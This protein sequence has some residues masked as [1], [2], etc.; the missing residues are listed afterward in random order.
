MRAAA[1][2]AH[3][4][5]EMILNPAA[6]LPSFTGQYV[7]RERYLTQV[8]FGRLLA[9][10]SSERRLWVEVAVYSGGRLSEVEGLIWEEHVHLD[11]A[12]MLLPG[13][14]TK[15][16]RRRVPI[17][18]PLLEALV[19]SPRR[20]GSVVLPWK[21]VRRDLA[22]ACKTAAIKPVTPND[23]RRTFASWMTQAGVDSKAVADLLGHT[24]TRMVDRCYGHLDDATY[25]RALA[26]LPGR[27]P[28]S[29]WVVNGGVPWDP[30]DG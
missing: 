7:P 9:Q 4:R 20:S 14:K 12:S 30:W 2:L 15:R 19:A 29:E 21:N 22:L 16:S 24:S 23:L 27:P 17:A 5:R 18:E 8:E 3:K 10:L 25:R 11:T 6:V 13:T 1:K 28:G 26:T